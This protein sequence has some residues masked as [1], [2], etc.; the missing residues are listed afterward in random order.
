MTLPP[1]NEHMYKRRGD[2]RILDRLSDGS[3]R[4]IPRNRDMTSIDEVE[5]VQSQ[6]RGLE[7]PVSGTRVVADRRYLDDDGADHLNL[8]TSLRH[9]WRMSQPK[10]RC[11]LS[12][13]GTD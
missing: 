9:W 13:R 6:A 11:V 1:E 8:G 4:E 3:S 7:L 12:S 5:I 10:K 2:L